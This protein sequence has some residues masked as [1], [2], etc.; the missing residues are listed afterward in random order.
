MN[1]TIYRPTRAQDARP[2]QHLEHDNE[3]WTIDEVSHRRGDVV[4]IAVL[5]RYRDTGRRKIIL[6]AV[7]DLV[8][9]LPTAEQL[10]ELETNVAGA[11]GPEW[12]ITTQ[13]D[14]IHRAGAEA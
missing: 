13:T 6:H 11:L 1:A 7:G 5:P 9:I 10:V 12:A 3:T 4:A 2:D 14:E 8:R